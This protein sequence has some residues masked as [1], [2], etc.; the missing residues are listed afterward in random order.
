ML[1]VF[2]SPDLSRP[3]MEIASRAMHLPRGS[4][5]LEYIAVKARSKRRKL[6]APLRAIMRSYDPACD[7]LLHALRRHGVRNPG[8]IAPLLL[9]IKASD[10]DDDMLRCFRDADFGMGHLA[11][12]ISQHFPELRRLI[13]QVEATYAVFQTVRNEW[14]HALLLEQESKFVLHRWA[15]HAGTRSERPIASDRLVGAALARTIREARRSETYL[16]IWEILW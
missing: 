10:S 9:K 11:L 3:I 12:E 15:K 16:I 2:N 8:K 14:V 5:R 1:S 4:Q 7:A 13:Q 6:S